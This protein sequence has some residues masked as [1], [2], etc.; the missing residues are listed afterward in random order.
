[1]GMKGAFLVGDGKEWSVGV[2]NKCLDIDSTTLYSESLDET[3][4]KSNRNVFNACPY[5]V[6]WC[7]K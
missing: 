3:S 2:W 7:P 6:V 1:M 4:S 5:P